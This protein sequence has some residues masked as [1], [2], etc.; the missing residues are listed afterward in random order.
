[1]NKRTH[2]SWIQTL[3]LGFL[4]AVAAVAL[5]FTLLVLGSSFSAIYRFRAPEPFSGPDIFNPYRHLDTALC[6]KG[7]LAPE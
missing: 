2:R 5:C 4:K 3:A 7:A 1:M 6:W